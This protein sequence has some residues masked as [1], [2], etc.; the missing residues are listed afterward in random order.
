MLLWM[1]ITKYVYKIAYVC[2]SKNLWTSIQVN[3][4]YK[5][6]GRWKARLLRMLQIIY[7]MSRNIQYHLLSVKT[8]WKMKWRK[9]L[10]GFTLSWTIRKLEINE[11]AEETSSKNNHQFSQNESQD[12]DFSRYQYSQLLIFKIFLI[13][14]L[15]HPYWYFCLQYS[16]SNIMN[17]LLTDRE[18]FFKPG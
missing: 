11:Q 8:S 9:W 13:Y 17:M 6:L 2:I 14:W 3:V 16:N 18:G 1:S 4:W 10:G 12:V 5:S 15:I 7:E